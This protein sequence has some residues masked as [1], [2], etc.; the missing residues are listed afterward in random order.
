MD[1]ICDEVE[2]L[3]TQKD[4]EIEELKR[5]LTIVNTTP[6][7]QPEDMAAAF[8]VGIS[9]VGI[10]DLY[11]KYH[12]KG[13]TAIV[14][15]TDFI[16]DLFFPTFESER[17]VTERVLY[18]QY[19]SVAPMVIVNQ[20]SYISEYLSDGYTNNGKLLQAKNP[21]GTAL[22]FL[23]ESYYSCGTSTKVKYYAQYLAFCSVFALDK[24]KYNEFKKPPFY[25]RLGGNMISNHYKKIFLKQ[26]ELLRNNS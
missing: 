25:I 21:Y 7:A 15:K 23:S 14:L 1:K 5:A 24:M 9:S 19:N 22:D 8:P 4:K 6:D 11:H 26:K 10:T 12:F 17:F 3:V 16:K 20:G 2:A 18:N 13:D